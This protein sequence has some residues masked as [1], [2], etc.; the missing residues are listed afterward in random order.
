MDYLHLIIG[1]IWKAEQFMEYLLNIT[2]LVV[3][4][5][6]VVAV[7]LPQ[8]GV[9]KWINFLTMFFN[10]DELR[11]KTY[12]CLPMRVFTTEVVLPL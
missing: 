9:I 12:A 5:R 3:C 8:T 1:T 2:N 4:S 10:S 6:I 7:Y 11:I